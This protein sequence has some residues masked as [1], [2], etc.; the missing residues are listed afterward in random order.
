MPTY[1]ALIE[2][3]LSGATLRVTP[4]VEIDFRSGTRYF[5]QGF[6]PLTTGSGDTAQEWTGMN[7]MGAI[8]QVPTGFTEGA[9]EVTFSLAGPPEILAR[10]RDDQEESLHRDARV[11]LQF[12][13]V[14]MT[15]E[16]VMTEW[17]PLDDPIHVF[18]GRM[19]PLS[20]ER[21]M[22]KE[23]QTPIRVVTV[24]AI[25]AL[26]NRRRPPLAV[27]SH[28]EQQIRSPGDQMFRNMSQML[29]SVVQW[30]EP[31]DPTP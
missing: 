8:T 16:E 14:A 12:L 22:A 28:T 17:Q 27:Y 29:E 3:Q 24:K 5:W 11:Y 31:R 7:N 25:S 23:G 18:W 6:G 1:D 26:V 19:G 13:R 9:P 20:I 15:P 21:R 4:L 30:P 10:I 2:A